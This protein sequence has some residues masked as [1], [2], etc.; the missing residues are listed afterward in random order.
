WGRSPPAAA[1]IRSAARLRQWEGGEQA[2][3]WQ[4][5]FARSPRRRARAASAGRLGVYSKFNGAD[6]GCNQ[7]HHADA[8]H[9]FFCTAQ[10][11]DLSAEYKSLCAQADLELVPSPLSPI[12]QLRGYFVL[13]CLTFKGEVLHGSL[14]QT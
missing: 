4:R 12:G 10:Y 9:R 7:P 11:C 5:P 2:E 6:K 14:I 8:D 3:I 13:H 1:I